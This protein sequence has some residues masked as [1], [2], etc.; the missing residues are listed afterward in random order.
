MVA[1]SR[2]LTC[3]RV[4]ATHW[5]GHRGISHCCQ[6]PNAGRNLGVWWRSTQDPR[7]VLLFHS[8]PFPSHSPPAAG[9]L[10]GIDAELAP[11]ASLRHRFTLSFLVPGE[12]TFFAAAVVDF[13]EPSALTSVLPALSTWLDAQLGADSCRAARL[14]DPQTILCASL[15]HGVSVVAGWE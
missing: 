14:S 7:P 6:C 15:P 13:K 9:M 10:S 1:D 8:I 5:V 3:G 4:G 12:Y 2:R 11:G